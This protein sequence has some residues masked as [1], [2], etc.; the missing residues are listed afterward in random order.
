[1]PKVEPF[2]KHADQYERWFEENRFAYASELE[3]V[4][5]LLPGSGKGIEIGVG[6]GR[7]AGPLDIRLGV[8]PSPVMR[9]VAQSRGITAVEGVAESLPFDDAL[10][11]FALMVTTICFLDDPAA[12]I[13]EAYRVMKPGGSL[14][15]GLVDRNSLLGRK[16]ERFKNENVFYREAHFY[17]I[18][19][20]IS[21]LKEGG[22][23]DLAFTQTIF[24][25][26]QEIH[27]MEP[28][29]EGYGEGSFI[30]VR[31]VK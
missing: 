25:D 9:A 4:R 17:S 30:V 5:A 3:A 8:E 6:T 13:R 31:G 12:A 29:K 10:F 7:F 24:Q 16:Y 27:E 26:L 28:V 22:F 21:L 20:V 2:D 11:D 14:L 18:D 15:I 1:L 23:K 19:E